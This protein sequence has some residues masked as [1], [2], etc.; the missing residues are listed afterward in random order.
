MYIIVMLRQYCADA[1]QA[2]EPVFIAH[3]LAETMTTE[4]LLW[5]WLTGMCVFLT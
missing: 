5:A 4:V 1:A 3:H 2:R